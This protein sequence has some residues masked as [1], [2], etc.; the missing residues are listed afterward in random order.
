M[1]VDR[2]RG[3]GERGG[4]RCVLELVVPN[5]SMDAA[6]LGPE[7]AALAAA[8]LGDRRG[9]CCTR[10][11]VLRRALR[12]PVRPRLRRRRLAALA[13]GVSGGRARPLGL[14]RREAKQPVG[15][16]RYRR[17]A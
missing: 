3:A 4:M 11:G 13:L 17:Q 10:R 12:P 15:E 5:A 14:G 8:V 9:G 1:G 7:L 6:C 16:R 2:C